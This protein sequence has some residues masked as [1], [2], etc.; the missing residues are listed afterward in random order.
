MAANTISYPYPVL[1]NGDDIA[2][3]IN[4]PGIEYTI[5]DE[6]IQLTA[7]NLSTGHETIDEL[8]EK[9]FASWQIR[10]N[11]ARTYMRENFITAGPEWTTNLAGPDY[12]GSVRLEVQVI[13]VRDIKNYVPAGAH[14]DYDDA[15]FHIK[16]GDL[17]AICPDYSFH[18]D[19]VY[20]P[21]KAPVASLL[22]VIEGEHKHGPF[23]LVLDDDLIFVK[24]SKTDWKEYA[25]IR[26]RVPALLHSTIVLSVMA[27]AISELNKY[28][29]TLWAGRIRDVLLKKDINT[30]YPLMAAQELLDSPLTRTF[31]EVNVKLDKGGM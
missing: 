16:S 6:A 30:D 17:L 31:D 13:A 11:C 24:L 28:E 14:E 12:E 5:T 15:K 18:V 20:D 8:V 2:A 10:L 22:R 3:E 26:D 1:G 9:G 21:L 4:V 27:A 25:G 23:Q 29:S 7:R 19:K